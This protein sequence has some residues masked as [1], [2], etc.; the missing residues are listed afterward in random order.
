MNQWQHGWLGDDAGRTYRGRK[1]FGVYA[2]LRMRKSCQWGKICTQK[3]NIIIKD[4]LFWTYFYHH[5]IFWYSLSYKCSIFLST[6]F[7]FVFLPT[8]HFY[9]SFIILFTSP[10]YINSFIIRM[11]LQMN[12]INLLLYIV[13]ALCITLYE[14]W[15]ILSYQKKV[16][17][18]MGYTN[19]KFV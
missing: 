6:W 17:Q 3:E 11:K 4:Y 12:I 7:P 18:I 2:R 1:A 16:P 19:G 15:K 5:I 9:I 14:T 10:K 8:V 13:L